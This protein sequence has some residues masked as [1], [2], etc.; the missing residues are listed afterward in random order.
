MINTPNAIKND[1]MEA[2]TERGAEN[3]HTSQYVLPVGEKR[4]FPQLWY[5]VCLPSLEA[6]PGLY[7]YHCAGGPTKLAYLYPEE[8]DLSFAISTPQSESEN[9]SK[10]E[11]TESSLD[12]WYV[13]RYRPH[14]EFDAVF[15]TLNLANPQRSFLSPFQENLPRTQLPFS[16]FL[17]AV[18]PRRWNEWYEALQ[19]NA[20]VQAGTKVQIEVKYRK[21]PS[22]DWFQLQMRLL[23]DAKGEA[24]QLPDL[25]Q[26]AEFWSYLEAKTQ[27]EILSL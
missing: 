14:R 10:Q 3:K 22:R 8:E 16:C 15:E 23:V 18:L 20:S 2:K 6:F 1:K 4:P 19:G 9:S 25:G 11:G 27:I 7:W 12:W 13:A 24:L 5:R 26:T 17:P 21:K